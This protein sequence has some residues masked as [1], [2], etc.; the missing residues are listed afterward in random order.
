MP[1]TG[2]KNGFEK[3]NVGSPPVEGQSQVMGSACAGAGPT[4]GVMGGMQTAMVAKKSWS[5][6]AGRL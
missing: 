2:S 5:V 4:G 3:C 1:G 6:T